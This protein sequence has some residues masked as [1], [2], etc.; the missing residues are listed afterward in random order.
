MKLIAF[1]FRD[2]GELY[3]DGWLSV[4]VNRES[5]KNTGVVVV[6][7]LPFAR[8]ETFPDTRRRLIRTAKRYPVFSAYVRRSPKT[9]KWKF[10]AERWRTTL[11][12]N[13]L[14]WA[15]KEY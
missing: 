10:I 15:D 1:K 11:N 2:Q 6:A 4:N 12:D 7:T 9:R 8:V 13:D 5:G 3:A 14:A